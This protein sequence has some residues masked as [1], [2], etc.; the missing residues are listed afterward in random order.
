MSRRERIPQA[1]PPWSAAW[2]AG[3]VRA[4]HESSVVLRAGISSVVATAVDG[5]V[6]QGI[7]LLGGRYGTASAL[8]AVLGA[9]TNFTINRRW[10][11]RGSQRGLAVQW[12]QYVLASAATY[13]VLRFSLYLLIELAGFDQHVAWIP[14]KVVAWALASYPIQ[15]F[16]VFRRRPIPL[17]PSPAAA[18]A[19]ERSDSHPAGIAGS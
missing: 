10:T 11:F 16:I 5:A 17:P 7:L 1:A 19:R 6:Y 13:L 8:A 18:A 15:R 4:L 9:L 12:F 14:A 2:R 3:L